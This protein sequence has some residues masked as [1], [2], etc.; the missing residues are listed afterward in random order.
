MSNL[1]SRLK[2]MAMEIGTG[3]LGA[4]AA[5][6]MT[7]GLLGSAL[8]INPKT[9]V[10][11][12]PEIRGGF[13]TRRVTTN[14]GITRDLNISFPLDCGDLASANVGQFLAA[15]FGVDTVGAPVSGI[16]PHVFSRLDDSQPPW[17]NIYSDKDPV[18]KQYTG[19]RAK[20]LKFTLKAGDGLINVDCTGSVKSESNFTN[21]G[22]LSFSSTQPV[23][24]QQAT[25]TIGSG[26]VNFEEITIEIMRDTEAFR[27][28]GPSRDI[29]DLLTKG[30]QI[31]LDFKGLTFADDTMRARFLAGTSDSM[32]LTLTDG[33]TTPNSL[34]FNFPE[35][36][37]TVFDGPDLKDQ[38][39]LKISVSALATGA[40]TGTTFNVTLNNLR[41]AAYTA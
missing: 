20:T 6:I 37:Y 18:A 9:D 7:H 31:K 39:I 34:V 36:F 25:L 21:P 35:I 16:Y 2:K 23:T 41:V 22:T 30:F 11:A 15:I 19:F 32:A 1:S 26:A 27:V 3:S 12:V 8:S 5:T 17:F 28:I 4:N 10:K 14:G 29:A 13:M 38:D 33:A 24:P 40:G